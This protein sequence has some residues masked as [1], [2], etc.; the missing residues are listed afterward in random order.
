M[1]ASTVP[2][3]KAAILTMLRTLP[4]LN[5]ASIEWGA[6]TEHE[7]VVGEMMYFEDPVT[8]QPSWR[9]LG[10]DYLDEVYTLTLTVAVRADG[11]D[12]ASTESRCWDLVALI[13]QTLRADT[14]LGGVLKGNSD[15]HDLAF[16]EQEVGST[17][18]SR[19]WVGV[20]VVPLICA[21]RI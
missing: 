13:E 7:D 4:D 3:A 6:P 11:D 9:V 10:G 2:A 1:A 19:G 21:S 20:A 12:Q 5:E 16:G 17:P 18:S 15:N 8:R 14:S